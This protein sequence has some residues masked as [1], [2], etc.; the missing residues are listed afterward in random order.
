M[1]VPE[2][3][4]QLDGSGE[5]REVEKVLYALGKEAVTN[6]LASSTMNGNGH[7]HPQPAKKSKPDLEIPRKVLH[8]SIGSFSP[9]M[10]ISAAYPACLFKVFSRYTYTY[11]KA[12][13]GPLFSF[14]GW[15]WPLSSLPIFYVSGSK[16][17]LGH[18]KG[19]SA[20]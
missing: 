10:V 20:S 12:M 8:A 18:T 4:E 11:Q 15:P 19:S 9:L 13:L 6:A 14:F 5:D 17:S 16:A 7:A 3:D 2:E 1:S